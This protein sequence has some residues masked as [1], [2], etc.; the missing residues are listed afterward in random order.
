MKVSA[1]TNEGAHSHNKPSKTER[2][3][4]MQR[5]HNL[6]EKLVNLKEA[7]LSQLSL[8]AATQQAIREARRIRAAEPRRRHLSYTAKLLRGEDLDLLHQGLAKLDGSSALSVS[9]Q[10]QAYRWCSELLTNPQAEQRWF[11]DHPDTQRQAFRTLLRAAKKEYADQGEAA[12]T[13]GKQQK[14]L[15]QWI[16]QQLLL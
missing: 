12:Q 2:K 5:L 16:R 7:Q 8:S 1:T 4:A 10:Q 6:A 15:V 11:D 9:A 3:R 14:K 13:P